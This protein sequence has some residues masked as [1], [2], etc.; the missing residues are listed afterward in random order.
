MA[1][2]KAPA[3]V[4]WTTRSAFILAATGSAVGL[5]NIWKFPYMAG[6]NGGGAFV[7]VYLLCIIMVGLPIMTAEVMLGRRGGMSPISSMR[8]LARDSGVSSRWAWVGGLGALSGFLLLTFYTV[9]GGWVLFYIAKMASGSLQGAT[10]VE[11][12]QALSD[13]LGNPWMVLAGHTLF[14]VMTLWV[15]GRG[16]HKGI[17]RSARVLMP[18]LFVLLIVLFGYAMTSP[19]F[20]EAVRFLFSFDFSKISGSSVIAAVGHSFF[21]LSIGLGAIMAYGAYMPRETINP[22]TGKRTPVS[23]GSTVL[24]VG[25]LDTVVALVAGLV[26]FPVVFAHGLAPGEGPGLLFVTLPVALS[27]V[28]G[29]MWVGTAFFVLVLCAA[30]TSSISIAEPPVAWLT[31]KG[32]SRPKASLMVG[33]AAWVVG[34][35]TVF[36]FNLGSGYT[37]FGMNFFE[38]LDFVSVNIMLP[39]GGFLIAIFAGWVLKETHARKELNMKSFSIYMVWRAMVR[40]FSPLALV[41]LVVFSLWKAL[42]G[43]PVAAPEPELAPAIEQPALEQPEG[44]ELPP[45]DVPAVDSVGELLPESE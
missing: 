33:A 27:D 10:T 30:W 15:V 14:M 45:P 40:I 32:I 28:L 12:Q 18:I 13:L 23:I 16:I 38:L 29:G 5:G 9:I 34:L 3:R 35:G 21:T 8:K 25:V 43:E 37:L 44:E 2:S 36:S 41:L 26:I 22:R 39:L 1:D 7:A 17:E 4:A 19:G 42:A 11:A 24:L 20:G 6:A 31:E